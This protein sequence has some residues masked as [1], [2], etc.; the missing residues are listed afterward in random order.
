M[1]S[2]A[3]TFVLVAAVLIGACGGVARP[4]S[5]SVPTVAETPST[6]V[7]TAET[8]T[9]RTSPTTTTAPGA[10]QT[11]GDE[12]ESNRPTTSTTHTADG[13]ASTTTNP[14]E[15]IDLAEVRDALDVLDALFG[16]LDDHIGSVDLDEGETP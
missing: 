1:T 4:E 10:A 6:S 8:P 16:D 7:G 9:T 12:V 14:A 13:P 11:V 3:L 15:S 2:K 5:R